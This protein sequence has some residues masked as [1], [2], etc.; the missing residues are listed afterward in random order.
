MWRAETVPPA[1]GLWYTGPESGELTTEVN[2]GLLRAFT[3]EHTVAPIAVREPAARWAQGEDPVGE[4]GEAFSEA[5]VLSTCNRTEIYAVVADMPQALAAVQKVLARGDEADMGAYL[6]VYGEGDALRHLYRVA[7]GIEAQVLGETQVL[8]QVRQAYRKALRSGSV[9]PV[10]S[11]AFAGAIRAARRV[12]TE[13]ALSQGALSVGHAAVALARRVFDPL[14]QRRVAVVG[15]G[16]MGRLVLEH[17]AAAGVRQVTVLS[18]SVSRA[19]PRADDGEVRPLADLP[20]VLGEV[21]LVLFASAA[22]GPILRAEALGR[23]LEARRGRPLFLFDLAVPRNVDPGVAELGDVFLYD[24]ED[25]GQVVEEN[26]RERQ[27][28]VAAAQQ[29]LETEVK[30][31]EE[32]LSA[33]QVGP[34]IHSLRQ[35]AEAVR[36]RELRRL[37]ARLPDLTD[38]EKRLIE[39]M[40]ATLMNKLLADPTIRVREAAIAGDGDLMAAFAQLFRLA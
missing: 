8:H 19:G 18:R 7:A 39:A 22:P 31:L 21:D 4:L 11:Q 24:L 25:L 30:N 13:T 2:R 23:V 33:R 14:A 26:L 16:E 15:M 10:L 36:R 5:V 9:G 32:R 1:R 6:R 3:V 17:L 34:Q 29:I 35:R 28:A 12:H 38:R 27:R 40:S 20:R 37:F